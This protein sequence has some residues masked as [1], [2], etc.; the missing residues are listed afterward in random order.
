MLTE[1]NLVAK[2]LLSHGW[3]LLN[4]AF[5]VIERAVLSRLQLI[6]IFDHLLVQT[7]QDGVVDHVLQNDKTIT[8][9]C[10][11]RDFDITLIKDTTLCLGCRGHDGDWC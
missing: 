3:I 5:V 11:N 4:V 1:I 10:S 7:I 9:E 2:P 6:C 8:S